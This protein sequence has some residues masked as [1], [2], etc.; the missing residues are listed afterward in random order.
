MVCAGTACGG[1]V[2][3][4]ETAVRHDFDPGLGQGG[5]KLLV[6]YARLERQ[7]RVCGVGWGH[8][9]HV[10]QGVRGLERQARMGGGGAWHTWGR[11]CGRGA[12]GAHMGWDQGEEAG[13]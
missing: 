13:P 12:V 1:L 4:L 6:T 2:V 8:M 10:G 5:L 9:A 7:A 11:G 3:H